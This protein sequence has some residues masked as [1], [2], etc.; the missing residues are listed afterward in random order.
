MG[1]AALGPSLDLKMWIDLEVGASG[2][3]EKQLIPRNQLKTFF[4]MTFEIDICYRTKCR[5]R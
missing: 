5:L 3:F 2:V 1:I 4:Y